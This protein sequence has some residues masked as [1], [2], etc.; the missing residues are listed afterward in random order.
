MSLVVTN[1]EINGFKFT[2][3]HASVISDIANAL[4]EN[5]VSLGKLA[6]AV[7]INGVNIDKVFSHDTINNNCVNN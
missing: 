5:A 1:C 4:L 2:E 3:E 7:N 6:D